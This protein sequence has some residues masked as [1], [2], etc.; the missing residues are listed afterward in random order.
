MRA[1]VGQQATPERGKADHTFICQ[2][3]LGPRGLRRLRLNQETPP[4]VSEVQQQKLAGLG[5]AAMP[6][7][8]THADRNRLDLFAVPT[9]DETLNNGLR[10]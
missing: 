10:T 5:L 9:E 1:V 6:E 2:P 7:T 3:K 8:R 4:V